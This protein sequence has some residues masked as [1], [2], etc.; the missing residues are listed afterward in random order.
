MIQHINNDFNEKVLEK[1]GLVLVDFYADWCGPCKM[2]T[3]VM[4]ELAQEVKAVSFIK[5]DVDQ[6]GKVA[7]DYQVQSIPTIIIFKNGEIVERF[8]GFRPKAEIANVLNKYI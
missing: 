8:A 3:P 6:E 1:E 7:M 2:L 4:E 5:L